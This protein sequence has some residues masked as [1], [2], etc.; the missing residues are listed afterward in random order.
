MRR[1]F[2][3]ETRSKPSSSLARSFGISAGSSW[4]SASIVTMTSPRAS[5]KPACSAAAFPKFRR[6]CTTTTLASSSCIRVSTDMLPSLDPSS[7][8]ITSN[9]SPCGSSAVGDLGIQRLERVLLVEQGND[10]GDHVTEGIGVPGRRLQ[11]SSGSTTWTG[12]P[13]TRRRPTKAPPA[14]VVG[15]YQLACMRI[16]NARACSTGMSSS[17]NAATPIHWYVPM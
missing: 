9:S 16:E 8:K 10:D 3:P 7:T 14:S 13:R 2:Q 4:R 6:R 17:P 11:P 1:V 12:L 15:T 5:R